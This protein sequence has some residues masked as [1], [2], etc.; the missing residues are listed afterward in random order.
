MR[1]IEEKPNSREFHSIYEF[2]AVDRVV[3]RWPLMC[4]HAVKPKNS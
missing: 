2:F 4:I 1:E 3:Y